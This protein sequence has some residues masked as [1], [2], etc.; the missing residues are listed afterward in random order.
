MDKKDVRV[1]IQQMQA[2]MQALIQSAKKDQ[3]RFVTL[4]CAEIERTAKSIM[5]DS[6]T[7]PDV[8]Y[9]KK[10][11]H[12]S[13]AGNPPAPDNG[14]LLQS[15]THSFDVDVSGNVTG[16]VGSILKNPDYPRF[17]EYGTSRMKPR[18]WLSASLIKCQTFMGNLFREI[19]GK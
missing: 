15:V 18:P 4:S 12:P 13:Y 7:N 6:P 11:H 9:G 8:T 19:F 3:L 2:E 1:Q 5:R 10:G 16:Y 14:T 17:L